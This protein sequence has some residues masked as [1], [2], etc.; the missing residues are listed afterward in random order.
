MRDYEKVSKYIGNVW[1]QRELLDF[2]ID[3]ELIDYAK[4]QVKEYNI[5]VLSLDALN[6]IH[7]FVSRDEIAKYTIRNK[8]NIIKDSEKENVYMNEG[9]MVTRKTDTFMYDLMMNDLSYLRRSAICANSYKRF[10]EVLYSDKPQD[11]NILEQVVFNGTIVP[12]IREHS[13]IEVPIQYANKMNLI[14]ENYRC[15]K[16]Q[17]I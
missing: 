2:I 15:G 4:D 10:L 11:N 1:I 12:L 13:N 17:T 16:Y 8:D 3:R 5:K 7:K 6:G 9:K 14:L